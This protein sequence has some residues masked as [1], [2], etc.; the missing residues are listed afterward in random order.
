MKYSLHPETEWDLREA[1][2]YYRERASTALS[3]AFF[4]EFEHSMQLLMRHPL[5]GKLWLF[6]KR[7]FVMKHFPYAVIYTVGAEEI[8][9]LAVAH[10]N[11][12]PG[13]WRKRK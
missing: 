3:Q 7:R 4:A 13:Y 12:R 10:H 6:G 1:A 11:R 8:R 5:L 2:A 9:V